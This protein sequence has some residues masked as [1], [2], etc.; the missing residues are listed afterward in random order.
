MDMEKSTNFTIASDDVDGNMIELADSA[1]ST[2]STSTLM[3]P[4]KFDGNLTIGDCIQCTT[5]AENVFLGELLLHNTKTGAILLME[6]KPGNVK[7]SLHFINS[8]LL[9]SVKL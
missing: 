7:S 3:F 6:Q 8:S 9:K 4:M 2:S 1:P 5:K